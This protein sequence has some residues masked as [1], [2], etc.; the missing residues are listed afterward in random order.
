[1]KE[2]RE[3]IIYHNGYDLNLPKSLYNLNGREG[4]KCEER[5]FINFVNRI[6][7]IYL[8]FRDRR[9]WEGILGREG[10][11]IERSARSN[12][13]ASANSFPFPFL[14]LLSGSKTLFRMP[15]LHSD[16][17]LKN[18]TIDGLN[19]HHVRASA[20]TR[21]E[22]LAY[23]CEERPDRRFPPRKRFAQQLSLRAR[24]NGIIR[25]PSTLSSLSEN[26]VNCCASRN[27]R[28]R[29]DGQAI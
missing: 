16:G 14:F 25:R 13:V 5:N 18:A 7:N 21:S 19:A 22:T 6:K 26:R 2:E 29:L 15:H 12:Q 1:M 23:R 27:W 24:S 3:R 17:I 10:C 4:E 11:V 8:I 28:E 20:Q 9:R